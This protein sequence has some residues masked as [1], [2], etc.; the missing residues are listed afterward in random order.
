M[1]T[2][3]LTRRINDIRRAKKGVTITNLC[4]LASYYGVSVAAMASRLEEMR[5]IPTGTWDNLKEGGFKVR[6]AQQ[7]LGLHPIPENADKL[8]LR[9]Q[10]LA[11]DAFTKGLLTEGMFARFL[12]VSRL[13]ARLATEILSQK[14][15]NAFESDINLDGHESSGVKEDK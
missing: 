3:G 9:Y 10:Y 6:E 14:T 11:F 1:P 5:L 12:E 4:T 2:S 15:E 7:K 13:D 8:P